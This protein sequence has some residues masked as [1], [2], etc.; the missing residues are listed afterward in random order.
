MFKSPAPFTNVAEPEPE[1]DFLSAPA[2][3]K[4]KNRGYIILILVKFRYVLHSLYD[5]TLL[6]TRLKKIAQ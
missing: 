6:F 1:L 3:I 2:I 4:F 5:H